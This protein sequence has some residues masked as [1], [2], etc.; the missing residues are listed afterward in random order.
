MGELLLWVVLMTQFIYEVPFMQMI[1]KQARQESD[2]IIIMKKVL[3]LGFGDSKGVRVK[4]TK[5]GKQVRCLVGC[6][7]LLSLLLINLMANV[8]FLLRWLSSLELGL[9]YLLFYAGPS[10][11]F[12]LCIFNSMSTFSSK[13]NMFALSPK[14]LLSDFY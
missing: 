7:T 12:C 1:C 10:I 11:F 2:N 5:V 9:F 6:L 13:A 8:Y 14:R 4:Q 3:R